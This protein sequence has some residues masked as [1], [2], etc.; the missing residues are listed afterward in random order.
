M[1][2]D[3]DA[4]TITCSVGDL[5]Q[6]SSYK[7]IGVDRGDSFRR[8][9][10]GQEIHSRRADERQAE[11]PLYRAELPV[12]HSLE[13][14]GWTVAISGRIDGISIDRDARRI[15]L[16]EV[17]S[18]HF[19][20]ELDALFRSSRLQRHLFQLMLYAYFLSVT[21]EYAGFEFL[22]Q[23][24]LI[25]LMTERIQI[26]DA[27]FEAAGVADAL[28]SAVTKIVDDTEAARALRMAK[29]DFAEK[30]PFPFDFPR[31]FQHE[32]IDAISQA[33]SPV[34]VFWKVE[35][36]KHPAIWSLPPQSLS[37]FCSTT[38]KMSK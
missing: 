4:R 15:V 8:M 1:K 31:P 7:R 16:E 37:P 24:V 22:P 32:M 12:A 9:W 14:K 5:V 25:D 30:L 13:V 10:I 28:L 23:L 38:N 20:L 11:D 29:R 2:I 26:H 6:D 34:F 3:F 17:K 18:V 19:D 27:P 33:S 36:Q 21:E 35:S